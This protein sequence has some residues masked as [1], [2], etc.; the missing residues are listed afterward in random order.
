MYSMS[1]FVFKGPSTVGKYLRD[2]MVSQFYNSGRYAQFSLK[3]TLFKC[4]VCVNSTTDCEI[5]YIRDEG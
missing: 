3:Q 2:H 5:Y 1:V 4:Q